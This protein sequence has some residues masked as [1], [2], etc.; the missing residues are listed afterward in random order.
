MTD[1][2][3][4]IISKFFDTQANF[5]KYLGISRQSVFRYI[6][7]DNQ[8]T[9]QTLIKLANDYNISP[10]W[11]LLGQGNMLLSDND[12]TNN[13]DIISQLQSQIATLQADNN[14]LQAQVEVLKS[15]IQANNK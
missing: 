9:I 12:K 8:L 2:I 11:L 14:K 4:E 13:N 7:G 5:A 1:R 6:N 15:L 10:N 3:K